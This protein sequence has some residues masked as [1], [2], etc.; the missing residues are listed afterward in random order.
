[1]TLGALRFASCLKAFLFNNVRQNYDVLD[2]RDTWWHT[3]PTEPNSEQD[4]VNKERKCLHC[5]KILGVE[6]LII[7]SESVSLEL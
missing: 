4:I 1:M 2:S 3:I 6:T 5:K 7:M